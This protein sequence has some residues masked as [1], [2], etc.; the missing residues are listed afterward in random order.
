MREGAGSEGSKGESN[1]RARTGHGKGLHPG[2]K[3]GSCR[4]WVPGVR[5]A[6][7]H[8]RAPWAE[9]LTSS[10][11]TLS[12]SRAGLHSGAAQNST[13]AIR[14]AAINIQ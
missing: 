6:D 5:A 12:T 11:A 1:K 8:S 4:P 9:A 10:T 13:Q 2:H 14:K 7:G 3:K